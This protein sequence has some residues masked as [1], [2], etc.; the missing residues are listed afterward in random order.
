[1][2]SRNI[3]LTTSGEWFDLSPRDRKAVCDIDNLLKLTEDIPTVRYPL[4]N[5]IPEII[6]DENLERS[7]KRVM[8][9]LRSADTR[10]GGWQKEK[11]VIDGI[12]CSPRMARYV[13]RKAEILATLKEQIGNGTFRIKNLKSFPTDDGPKVRIVQAP[14]VIERIG[15]NAIMEPL[16]NRLSSL[17]I[18]TTAA[19]IQGRG[20][21][22]LFHQIQAAIADNPRLQYYYQSDYKGYYDNINH[23]GLISIIKRYVGDPI[24]LP[25]LENFVKA[26]YPNGERGI[27][28]GLRS[29]QFFGNLYHNDIDHRMI[30]VHG[31]GYYFRFC[32]DIFILG[33][34]KRELWRLRDCLHIEA[35]KIGLTIKTSE[36]VAPI[37]SG[38]DALGFVNYGDYTLLRKRT[39]VNAARKLSKLKSRRRRRQIIGS[40]KGMAC[41]ADCKHLFYILTKK[42]MK[43]FSEMGV[44]YTPTD[45]KKRFPGKV[46]RLSDIVN[47]PIEIH[48]FETGIDTKEGEDRYLV[49]FRNPTTQ[50][51]G[52]FFT[53]SVEMK[54]ILDQISDIEDGFPFETVLKCEMFDGGKRKYNFT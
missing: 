27:S 6:S 37:F 19:S 3:S 20:P 1:M 36:K 44:T 33:E 16:E 50:E 48:D 42:N 22:G 10:K 24:L 28:K 31:T 17:L 38:M 39:K 23:S 34:S 4:Y 7:F 45:G 18:E 15:S 26:L 49:S 43:K 53:A 29:S 2:E 12:E 11:V 41:H 47:I 51:W 5:L 32:D 8:A 35:D 14:S 9:N 30:D 52:K 21:H 54:G 40:F 46:M 13:R 25:I